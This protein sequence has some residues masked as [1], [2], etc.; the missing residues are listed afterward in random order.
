MKLNLA[1]FLALLQAGCGG[2]PPPEV[3]PR[4]TSPSTFQY[5]EELWDAGVEGETSLRVFINEQGRVDSTR[6]EESSGYPA[7]DSAAVQGAGRLA[8]EPAR[9]GEQPV[10]VWVLLPVQFNL[11]GGE[12]PADG[13]APAEDEGGGE[14]Q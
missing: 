4:Q 8:F 11:E 1:I 3:P 5:P 9:R 2:E 14:G 7:F 10:G 12:A 13:S 6:V